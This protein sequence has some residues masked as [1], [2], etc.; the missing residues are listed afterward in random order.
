ILKETVI[1]RSAR[2]SDF[3]LPV[4]LEVEI[5]F[6]FHR[7]PPEMSLSGIMASS[8]VAPAFELINGVFTENPSIQH[9]I[10]SNVRHSGVLFGDFRRCNFPLEHEEVV[11]FINGKEAGRGS[12]KNV[13]G[14]P[15]APV[16][17]LMERL[18]R[19]GERIRRGDLVISGTMIPPVFVEE[20]SEIR[21][22]YSNLGE[23]ELS[24]S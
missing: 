4:G 16:L 17:W 6:K 12:G 10:V 3:I 15:A 19:R 1:G 5:A 24:L 23:L 8:K 13:L 7:D 14:H 18:E 9:L 21:A 2:L 20:P 22:S 11:L